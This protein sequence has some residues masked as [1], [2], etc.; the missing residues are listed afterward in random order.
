MPLAARLRRIFRSL[1]FRLTLSYVL[2]FTVMLAVLGV[3]FRHILSNRLENNLQDVLDV[4]WAAMKGYIKIEGGK[5]DW[6]YDSQDDD[7]RFSVERLKRIYLVAD[8]KGKV[9]ES[10]DWYNLIGVESPQDIQQLVRLALKSP[11]DQGIFRYK[12]DPETASRVLLRGGIVFANDRI[13]DA[14][15]VSIGR[16]AQ[17]NN[18]VLRNFTRIYLALMPF[19][20]FAG[21]MFGWFLAGRSLRPVTDVAEAAGR[22]SGSNLSLRIPE[23]GAGDQ[24]DH[25]IQTFNRMVARLDSSF[26]QIRQFSTDVSHE[27]RTP[28]TAIR[29]QLEVALFTAKNAAQYREAI[30]NSLQ[31]IDRL[32]Q[33]VRAL[34]LLAQSESGQ[35]ELQKSHLDLSSVVKNLIDQFQIPAEEAG[36]SLSADLPAECFAELDR[37]QVERLISNL[38]SNAIKFTPP[39][40]SVHLKVASSPGSVE[41]IVTDTGCGMEKEHL[42]HIFDRFYRIPSEQSSPERGLGLGLSFVAWIVKAHGGSIHVESEPGKGSCF[43]VRLPAGQPGTLEP[44]AELGQRAG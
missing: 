2:F 11:P 40:G 37:V 34:L 6:D 27:L 35:V 15:F 3:M 17:Q 38:V 16:T 22:I 4:D 28:I 7:E 24:L 33:I 5:V 42:S 36:V 20:I 9:L 21:S 1:G 32:S 19:M 43:H 14:Y 44:A 13:H 41:I 30:E 8:S 31:D 25:L 23:R 26:Q 12:W 10:S 39:G 29:G 18:Q